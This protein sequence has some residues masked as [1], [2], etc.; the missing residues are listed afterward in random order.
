MVVIPKSND[1]I[2]PLNIVKDFSFLLTSG[3][4]HNSIYIYF[5]FALYIVQIFVVIF[6][7]I[8]I[9]PRI[10]F[11]RHEHRFQRK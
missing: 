7:S 1:Y 2:S 3:F 6:F 11:C 4:G 9:F 10:L 5:P 8:K